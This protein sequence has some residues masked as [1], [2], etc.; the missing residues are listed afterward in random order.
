MTPVPIP[1]NLFGIPFGIAGL[2]GTWLAFANCGHVSEAIGE[3]LLGLSA[4]AWL[5]IL[6]GYGRYAVADPRRVVRDLLDPVAAPFASLVLIT[7]MLLA[8]GGIYP[9]W[10]E[11]GRV[12]LDV[13]LV[14]TV[15]LG[16]WFIGQWIYTP[17]DADAIHPGYFLPTVAGGLIAS[18]GA[19][20]VGQHR[21]AEVMFGL[22]V[23]SWIV[24]GSVILN[25]LMTRPL[26]PAPSVPTLAIQVAP[27]AVASLAWFALHGD[28]LDSVAA[29]LGGY[30]LLMV[31]AQL[32]LVRAYAR[33]AF[34]PSTWAFTFGWTAVATAGLH[35]LDG[36]R[37]TGYHVYDY[38]LVAAITFLVGGIALRT[39][40][41]VGRGQLLPRPVPTPQMSSLT[42][43][44]VASSSSTPEAA[45]LASRR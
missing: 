34:M 37:P 8:A 19:A 10:H 17:L 45:E 27:A 14:L 36:S 16:G 4:V 2:G 43:L 33:L 11:T 3:A 40:L 12:L 7:P 18:A 38:L 24:L 41:A 5:A 9:H 6:A 28:D 23:I 39:V 32:R 25:R 1:L 22:G 30:G 29:L 20:A 35:W 26:P 15:L 21:L 44:A 13:C 42:Q 31:L